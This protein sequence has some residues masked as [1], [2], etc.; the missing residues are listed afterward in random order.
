MCL[1]HFKKV[2]CLITDPPPRIYESPQTSGPSDADDSSDDSAEEG[3]DSTGHRSRSPRRPVPAPRGLHR[4]AQRPPERQRQLGT[5]CRASLS[6]PLLF[7]ASD[8]QCASA[9]CLDVAGRPSTIP[10]TQP[11]HVSNVATP[12][13]LRGLLQTDASQAR[14]VAR[15]ACT[16]C[17]EDVVALLPSLSAALTALECGTWH[18]DVCSIARPTDVVAAAA[19][20]S[21]PAHS[22][23]SRAV[24]LRLSDL[25]PVSEHQRL[26]LELQELLPARQTAVEFGADWLDADLSDVLQSPFLP[27]DLASRFA[28]I[29]SVWQVQPCSAPVALHVYTDGSSGGGVEDGY[30]T[31]CAWA[32][33]VWVVYQDQGLL[34]GHSAHSSV[35]PGTCFHCGEEDCTPLTAERLALL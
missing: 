7:T 32:F 3:H 31:D 23:S 13:R 21:I 25:C 33:S 27:R 15:G 14:P 30:L 11:A 26:T 18:C 9:M 1:S 6:C 17:T 20:I 5:D 34:L 19:Q 35:P 12:C 29:R 4:P 28:Q 10:S 2:T 16:S 8:K 24:P 22:S